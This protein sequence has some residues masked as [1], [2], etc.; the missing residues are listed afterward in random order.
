MHNVLERLRYSDIF[1]LPS[2]SEG[3]SLALTEAMS[4]GLPVVGYKN[5]SSVN[6]LIVN[7]KNGFL[8]EDGIDDLAE[9]LSVLMQNK[10]LRVRFGVNSHEM[11]KEYAPKKIWDKWENLIN[12]I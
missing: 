7:G 3:F 2:E 9:K 11:M 5:C 4:V 10:N 6:E 1:V 8:C 12:T